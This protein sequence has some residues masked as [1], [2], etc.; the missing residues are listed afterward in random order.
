MHTQPEARLGKPRG[1]R[2]GLVT[3]EA[4]HVAEL[5]APADGLQCVPCNFQKSIRVLVIEVG[6]QLSGSFL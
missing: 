5:N 6:E 4:R 2:Y 3:P 1:K